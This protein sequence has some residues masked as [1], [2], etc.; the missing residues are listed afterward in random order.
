V[1]ASAFDERTLDALDFTAIRDRLAR[2]AATQLGHERLLALSPAG[3]VER[4]AL[5][6]AATTEMRALVVAHDFA[7]PRVDDLRD[8][9]ARSAV[10]STLEGADLRAIAHALAAADTA[11]A[12][13]RAA[14]APVLTARCAGVRSLRSIVNR[15]DH[16]IDERGVVLERASPALGRI[17]RDAANALDEAR[18]R[19]GAIAR[20]AANR[21]A[22]QDALVTIRDGRFVVPVKAEAASAIPGIVH[23]TSATGQTLYIEPLSTVETNNRVRRLRLEEER[24]V[25]RILAEL[26]S[27]VGREAADVERNLEALTEID[28]VLAR[29][30]V[31]HQMN[32]VAP[33]L[34]D[35][36]EFSVRNGSH[37]LLGERAVA[38]SL[39]LDDDVRL[40]IV[41]GPNMG[42]KT[43]SL[44]MTGLFVAMT[45]CGMHLPASEATVGAFDHVD[46]ALGDEQSIAL[47]ASTFSAHLARLRAILDRAG[48]RSLVLIDEIASGTEAAQ[49]AALAVA[50]LETLLARGAHTIVTTH[51]TELKLF[52]QSTAAARNASVRFDPATHAPTY[53]LDIGTPGASL[54]FPLARST[55]IDEAIVARAE[56]LLSTG[57]RTYEEALGELAQRRSELAKQRD[58]L[59]RERVHL[60]ALQETA[61]RRADALE[62]ERRAIERG[63]E[64]RLAKALREFTAELERRQARS[65]RMTP[66]RS[67]LLEEVLDGVRRDLGITPQPDDSGAPPQRFE[68][69]DVVFA[70][71]LGTQADVVEDYG[72]TVLVAAGPL[73]AVVAKPALRFVRKR[74]PSSP[75]RTKRDRADAEVGRVAGARTELDVRGM[76]FAEA[77]PIVE[78]WLDEAQL[79]GLDSVRLIHGKGTGLLGRGL[80]E[81]L[82]TISGV[83][84]LR[85]GNA[86]EGG[87]GVTVVELGS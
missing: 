3:D 45:Y 43:V 78:R 37:P 80:Q 9:V 20:S 44:K 18:E 64:E 87:S 17:R 32:A 60:N 71:T 5:E 70:Q 35:R 16:A 53:Q 76:R 67:A 66:G 33:V 11:L 84:S 26:S 73:K 46:C 82:R 42:G 19:T 77:E 52:A 83:Q 31:A 36:P 57:E 56:S 59:E 7:L 55:G 34:S 25:A 30:I 41:S 65:A 29:A 58:E 85:Y 4:I 24:E 47:S 23:D 68:S 54:A 1:I 48:P 74:A 6:Q 51:A 28:V 63:A 12:A 22:I 79:A 21:N 13:V 61:R 27:I 69:G 62:R 14:D 75:A 15:I 10:G 49:G 2:H 72:D 8:A 50:I 81:H 39:A 86:D 40:L 38:Q